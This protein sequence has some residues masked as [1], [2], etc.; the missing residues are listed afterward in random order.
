MPSFDGA[1]ARTTSTAELVLP[2]NGASA[3]HTRLQDDVS[4]ADDDEL[5]V[6]VERI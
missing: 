3:D 6:A 1:N 5:G 4:V 2:S